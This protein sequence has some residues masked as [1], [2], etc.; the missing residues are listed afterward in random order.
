[1]LTNE[2]EGEET[3]QFVKKTKSTF[4]LAIG[5]IVVIGLILLVVILT[6]TLNADVVPPTSIKLPLLDDRSTI[7]KL[8]TSRVLDVLYF[9]GSDDRT[10][11]SFK[12]VTEKDVHWK[13]DPEGIITVDSYGRV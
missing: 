7:M 13:V 5:I 10:S 3:Q 1:M 9:S 4:F 2:I 8:G 11:D 6:N 12:S